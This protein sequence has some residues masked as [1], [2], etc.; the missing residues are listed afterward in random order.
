MLI[1]ITC[2]SGQWKILDCGRSNIEDNDLWMYDAVLG[3]K[4]IDP[5]IDGYLNGN[6]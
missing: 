6:S 5:F 1:C 4:I 2:I 3:S